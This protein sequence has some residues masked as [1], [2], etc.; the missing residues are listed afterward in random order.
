MFPL[1]FLRAGFAIF[2]FFCSLGPLRSDH[3][4][5][6]RNSQISSSRASFQDY[7]GALGGTVICLIPRAKTREALLGSTVPS[8]FAPRPQFGASGSFS[9]SA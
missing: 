8:P 6:P 7:L 9:V 2:S 3:S 5:A 4:A 1:G